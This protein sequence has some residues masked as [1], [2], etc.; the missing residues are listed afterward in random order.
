M[1]LESH[2]FRRPKIDGVI[3]RM[4]DPVDVDEESQH[5]SSTTTARAANP[6]V[7]RPKMG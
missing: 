3:G 1:G 6:E 4:D 5:V 7:N 2:L